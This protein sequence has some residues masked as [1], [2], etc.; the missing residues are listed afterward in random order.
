MADRDPQTHV[1]DAIVHAGALG[2]VVIYDRGASQVDVDAY[3][4]KI[5]TK[6]F[7]HLLRDM[8]NTYDPP[9]PVVVSPN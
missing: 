9:A 5:S 6:E 8:A 2:A 4:G 3:V 1:R 7:A